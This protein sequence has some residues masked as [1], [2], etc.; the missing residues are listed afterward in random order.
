MGVDTTVGA[1]D[2][3]VGPLEPGGGRRLV[4]ASALGG[5]PAVLDQLANDVDVAVDG[6]SEQLHLRLTDVH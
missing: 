6:H 4:T 5:M 3:R 2:V 1:L